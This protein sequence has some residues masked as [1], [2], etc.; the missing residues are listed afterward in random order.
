L[1]P[2]DTFE[3]RIPL[4]TNIEVFTSTMPILPYDCPTRCWDPDCEVPLGE[5]H[6]R[7]AQQP[8]HSIATCERWQEVENLAW[9]VLL[10]YEVT[11]TECFCAKDVVTLRLGMEGLQD[12]MEFHRCKSSSEGLAKAVLWVVKA[13]RGLPE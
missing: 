8:G 4:G 1:I 3:G 13:W 2:A 10:H 12:Q 11:V 7:S 5:C 6:E 9:L